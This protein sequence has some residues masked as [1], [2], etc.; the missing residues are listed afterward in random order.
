MVRADKCRTT[1]WIWRYIKPPPRCTKCDVERVQHSVFRCMVMWPW[2]GTQHKLSENLINNA[3]LVKHFSV[4]TGF[5]CVLNMIERRKKRKR[6]SNL[7][8][9]KWK[10]YSESCCWVVTVPGNAN[11][12]HPGLLCAAISNASNGS[13]RALCHRHTELYLMRALSDIAPIMANAMTSND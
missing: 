7:H 3:A 12:N 4:P 5:C 11:T 13:V 9:R 8:I 6:P 10:L 1:H 2:Q